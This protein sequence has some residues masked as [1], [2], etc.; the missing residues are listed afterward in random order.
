MSIVVVGGDHLG[1]IP[2]KLRQKGFTE[3]QHYQGRKVLKF[4]D[5]ISCSTD[6]ILVLTDY[7]GTDLAKVVKAEAKK[8][9]LKVIF[10]RRSWASIQREFN[11]FGYSA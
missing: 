8:N 7:V 5:K 11:R 10:S 4:K 9:K 2:D 3:I 6:L 1:S